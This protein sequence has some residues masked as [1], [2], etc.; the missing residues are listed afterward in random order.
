[1]WTT[2][3]IFVSKFVWKPP[4]NTG[5]SSQFHDGVRLKILPTPSSERY[6]FQIGLKEKLLWKPGA[7]F[8]TSFLRLDLSEYGKPF[9]LS[10]TTVAY[11]PLVSIPHFIAIDWTH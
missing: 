4:R 8:S 6:C 3:L 5:T 11:Y 10:T 1:M 7:Q 2:L 9:A